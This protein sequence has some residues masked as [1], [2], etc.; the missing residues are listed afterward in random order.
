MVSF[1]TFNMNM[2]SQWEKPIPASSQQHNCFR[3]GAA[4]NKKI[5][6]ALLP[7]T[8]HIWKHSKQILYFFTCVLKKN[9]FVF[10]V[11][12]MEKMF[13]MPQQISIKFK[14]NFQLKCEDHL[15]QHKQQHLLFDNSRVKKVQLNSG[16]KYKF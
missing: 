1:L 14:L 7:P 12:M 8:G 13:S 6:G 9:F 3:C 15:L 16:N 11:G 4:A 5:S 10:I 2:M